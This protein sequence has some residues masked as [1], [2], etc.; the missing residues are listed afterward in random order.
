[1]AH[2]THGDRKPGMLAV[3]LLRFLASARTDIAVG[4]SWIGRRCAR[5]M[6][7]TFLP[8]RGRDISAAVPGS[9]LTAVREMGR[10]LPELTAQERK[11]AAVCRATGTCAAGGAGSLGPVAAQHAAQVLSRYGAVPRG[12][13]TR[14]HS[15]R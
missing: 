6:L 10:R 15:S 14:L 4:P 3:M 9:S 13:C 11:L 8:Y 1:M 7:D 5:W 2:G 12:Y